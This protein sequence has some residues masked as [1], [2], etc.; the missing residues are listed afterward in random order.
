VNKFERILGYR[1]EAK[2]RYGNGEFHVVV[3]G[4]YVRCA[5]TGVVIP[6]TQLRY[7]SVELQEAYAGPEASLR[8]HLQLGKKRPVM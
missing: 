5:V 7:W 3:Q 6:L 1:G 8:R 4:D 2:V